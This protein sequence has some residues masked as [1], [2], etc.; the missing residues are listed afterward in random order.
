[1]HDIM[2]AKEIID[3][4]KKIA[5]SKNLKKIK[6]VYVEIGSVSLAHDDYPEH[7]E[8]V[9]LENLQFGLKNIAK[10]KIFQNTQFFLNRVSGENWKITDI[11]I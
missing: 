7:T 9:S 2:L 1:M 5:E 11:E 8:D 6:K 4:L 3:E 10:D